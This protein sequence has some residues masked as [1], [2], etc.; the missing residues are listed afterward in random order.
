VRV[1]ARQQF[2]KRALGLKIATKRLPRDGHS[3]ANRGRA[4]H[5]APS[6]GT[7]ALQQQPA[8]VE[9]LPPLPG[10]GAWLDLSMPASQLPRV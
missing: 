10:N 5:S 8:D 7:Y 3:V 6:I 9:Q 1:L 2:C 4:A